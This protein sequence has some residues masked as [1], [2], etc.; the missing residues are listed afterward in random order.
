M[1]I[2]EKTPGNALRVST[3]TARA[4]H[5]DGDHFH[6]NESVMLK[7]GATFSVYSVSLGSQKRV[8]ES[9]VRDHCKTDRNDIRI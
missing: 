1:P 4:R 3:F 2:K 7:Y 6:S 5:Y 8:E 9:M